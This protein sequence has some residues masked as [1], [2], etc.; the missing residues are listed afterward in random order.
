M[1]SPNDPHFKQLVY[2]LL[3]LPLPHEI[4]FFFFLQWD[5]IKQNMGFSANTTFGGFSYENT[6]SSTL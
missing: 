1:V 4:L 3:D 6:Y 2:I 5:H